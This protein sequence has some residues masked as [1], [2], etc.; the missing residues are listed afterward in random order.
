MKLRYL[1]ASWLLTAGSAAAQ[2]P[3]GV[4]HLA[5]TIGLDPHTRVGSTVALPNHNLVLLLSSAASPDVVAQCLAPDGH[6][7]W[8]TTLTRLQQAS[9]SSGYLLFDTRDIALGHEARD[10]KQLQKEMSAAGIFPVNVFTDGN[11]V[12][13]A[14]RIDG[15]AVKKQPKNSGVKLQD[16]QLFVQRLDAQGGLTKGWPVVCAAPRC[17]G[18]PYQVFV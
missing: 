6:T 2:V 1:L 14:E 16:G 10:K 18:R 15:D 7:L 12:V 4:L 5:Q 17:A 13:L 9:T 3:T 11:D 8:K